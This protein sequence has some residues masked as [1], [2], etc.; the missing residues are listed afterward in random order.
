MK[1]S[2]ISLAAAVVSLGMAL[3]FASPSIYA[4][5][6][7]ARLEY[8]GQS[9]DT[10]IADFMQEKHISGMT[11]AIVEA[12][13]I[14]RVA[15]Y[16]ESDTTKKLLASQ[17]TLWNIGP[18]TQ[19]YTAAAVMQLVEA[20]KMDLHAP[21]SNYVKGLPSAWSK[22]TVMQ[23]LQH[24]TG[25]ADYRQAPAYDA[26][27]EYQPQQ[28][29]DLVKDDKLTFKPGTAVAQSATNF[30][31]LGMAIE[32][33]SGM[34]Y[35]DFIWNGQIKPLNLTHTMFIEDFPAHAAIDPVEKTGMRHHMFTTDGHYINPV[36]P[37]AGYRL[38]DGKLTDAPPATSSSSFAFG[39]LWASAEDVSTWDIGLAG[40]EVIKEA[41]HRDLIYKPTRL[42]NGT[43][44]PAMAGWQFTRH[45]GFMD[46]KGN[47]PGY[48][49][50]LSRFTDPDELVCVTLLANTEGVDLT[51][52]ARRIA[53]AYDARL[54][55]GN[56]PAQT[57]TYES[58]FGVKETVARLEK[59]IKAANGQIFA[60]FDHQMNAQQAGLTM[61]PTE[62]IVFG[63]PAAGTRLMQAQPGIASELP[64]RV[65]VWEDERGRTWVSYTNFDRIAER[66]G[67]HDAKTIAAMKAGVA[68]LVRKSSS[69]Y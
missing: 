58:V 69:A 48:S 49:A 6:G 65:A 9:I 24:A 54:G 52:L 36:E 8:Y 11:M 59:N 10:M 3:S 14:P 50:Y 4:A 35:H 39:S 44:V 13:Y 64:L 33:T 51:D 18:I 5:R 20:G 23:L 45:K 61:R 12:P 63:N 7:D 53:S 60:H 29:L 17:G 38:V 46:I 37:A 1:T 57:S 32:A 16:G 43:V 62:V 67:I 30:L 31:L 47:A 2:S 22:L 66:Y 26:T 42:D 15:G 41:A 56:D 25:L 68:E 34:S 21:I 40:N 55:S 19:G 28:L 27:R